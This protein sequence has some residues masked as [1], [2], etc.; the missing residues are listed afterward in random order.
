MKVDRPPGVAIPPEI[1]VGTDGTG[2]GRSVSSGADENSF[3]VAFEFLRSEEL[4]A[5]EFLR[6]FQ[7]NDG[8][9]APDTLDI[10]LAGRRSPWSLRDGGS[11]QCQNH[12]EG[13]QSPGHCRSGRSV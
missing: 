3:F 2:S 9:I 13:N 5:F 8:S 4:L 6:P 10:R 11:D 1:I 7:R 12:N